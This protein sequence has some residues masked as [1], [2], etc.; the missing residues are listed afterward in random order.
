[1]ARYRSPAVRRYLFRLAGLMSAYAGALIG[2]KF[3]FKAGLGTGYGAYLLALA[4]AVPLI[5]VFWAIGRLM[6][7]E[8]DEYLRMQFVRQCLIATAFCLTITTAREFLQNFDLISD[9]DRGFGAAFFWF[10][11]LGLGGIWN[12]LASWRAVRADR[13]A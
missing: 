3:A 6:M 9:D 1:M 12:G 10:I 4:P 5:G 7:E 8:P 2:A 13:G 11:G